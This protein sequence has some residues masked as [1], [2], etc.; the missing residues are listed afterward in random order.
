MVKMHY[1]VVYCLMP[2]RI[3]HVLGITE[4]WIRARERNSGTRGFCQVEDEKSSGIVSARL[5]RLLLSSNAT[6]VVSVP[7]HLLFHL[8]LS[9]E[10][11]SSNLRGI[12]IYSQRTDTPAPVKTQRCPPNRVCPNNY[13]PSNRLLTSNELL[14]INDRIPGSSGREKQGAYQKLRVSPK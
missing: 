10:C 8:S 4:S 7:E 11:I 14:I 9:C 2:W 13:L 12:F 3:V 5:P 6:S 1:R